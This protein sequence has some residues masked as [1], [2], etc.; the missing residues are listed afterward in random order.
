MIEGATVLHAGIS[1]ISW[2][3]VRKEDGVVKDLVAMLIDLAK[4]KDQ[5]ILRLTV[6]VHF[7]TVIKEIVQV[8]GG[9]ALILRILTLLCNNA[10]TSRPLP[11]S[12]SSSS[13]LDMLACHYS[14]RE[15]STWN[16]IPENLKERVTRLLQ[17]NTDV[18][19]KYIIP[20]NVQAKT[21]EWETIAS[22]FHHRFLHDVWTSDEYMYVLLF[23]ID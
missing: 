12:S 2:F 1:L 22:Q 11:S 21:E 7:T 14:L 20:L 13:S 16:L 8:E 17:T 19:D 9:G 18:N 3:I 4:Q 15:L 5:L 23:M 6:L 10:G